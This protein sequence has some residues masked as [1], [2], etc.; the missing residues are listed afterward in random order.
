[1]LPTGAEPYPKRQRH[2]DNRP[3]GTRGTQTLTEP[4]WAYLE[5]A[6]CQIEA[7]HLSPGSYTDGPEMSDG[8]AEFLRILRTHDTPPHKGNWNRRWLA[9]CQDCSRGRGKR[10]AG[11]TPAEIGCA[12]TWRF[13][14]WYKLERAFAWYC[15]YSA[16]RA[17]RAA[18]SGETPVPWRAPTT[19]R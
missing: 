16:E 6:A 12:A 2:E 9:W 8:L 5:R 11:I 10:V 7:G 17:T 15:S 4:D 3:A 1:M 13:L 18:S 14:C 19:W